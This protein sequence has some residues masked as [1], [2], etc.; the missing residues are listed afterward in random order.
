[1]DGAFFEAE[2]MVRRTY[3]CVLFNGEFDL[4]SI[5]I[6]ELSEVVHKFV[7]VEAN[8][9]F[10]G[11]EKP[12]K[13]MKDHPLIKDYAD[14]LDFVLVDDMPETENAWDRE[15]WQRNS[16]IRALDD[17]SDEDL[18]LMSDVDEIPRLDCVIEAIFDRQAPAFGFRMSLYYFYMNYKNIRGFNNVITTVAA[19]FGLLRTHPPDTLRSDIRK[20]ALRARIF[21]N[22]GWHFSYLMD[23]LAIRE[24]IR[25]F[26]HQEFNRKR[27]LKRVNIERMVTESADLFGRSGFEWG[28]VDEPDLPL[29]VMEHKKIFQRYFTTGV[30]KPRSRAAMFSRNLGSLARRV[31]VSVWHRVKAIRRTF[32]T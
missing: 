3:D 26:S 28:I 12:V 6:H 11:L 7:V 16:V 2:K 30:A 8:K 29:Y 22:G 18:I 19:P 10:S 15:V 23:E 14:R 31:L 20:E 9:T 13:F 1:M 5:R 21:D 24:K 32:E 27:F 4:L 25:S 17:A